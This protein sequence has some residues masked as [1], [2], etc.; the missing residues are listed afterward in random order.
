MKII[1]IKKIDV[2]FHEFLFILES[3][4]LDKNEINSK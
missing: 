2:T 4:A 1:W 3:F